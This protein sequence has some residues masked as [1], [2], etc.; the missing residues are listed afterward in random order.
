MLSLGRAVH[1]VAAQRVRRSIGPAVV[2]ILG[3]GLFGLHVLHTL[4][5]DED[6]AA[7]VFG[8]LV[9]MLFAAAV[10]V[11][12]TWLWRS[13]YTGGRTLLIAA[14]ATVGGATL[15]LGA[16]F[17]ILY[18]STHGVAMDDPLFV[19]ADAASFGVVVGLVVGVS[20]VRQRAARASAERARDETERLNRRMTVLYRVLRHDLRNAATVIQGQ[21]E[22]IDDAEDRTAAIVASTEDLVDIGDQVRAIEHIASDDDVDRVPLDI[23]AVLDEQ[24]DQVAATS[25]EVAVEATLPSTEILAYDPLAGALEALFDGFRDRGPLERVSVDSRLTTLPDGEHVELSISFGGVPLPKPTITAI[26][27]GYETELEHAE[28]LDLWLVTWIV[29]ES[30]GAVTFEREDG[31]T[32]VTFFLEPAPDSNE[33]AAGTDAAADDSVEDGDPAAA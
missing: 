13:D 10:V 11:A 7:F 28:G 20:D 4:G 14:W 15:A 19:V 26:E 17:T 18:Q 8:I 29:E 9:P 22:L 33:A 12:A 6:L 5:E 25:P 21:A 32:T 30:G 27:R 16:M 1:A 31:G 23:A 24:L 2:F 3:A